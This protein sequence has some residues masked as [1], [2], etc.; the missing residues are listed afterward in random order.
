MPKP[1]DESN[2]GPIEPGME[3][4]MKAIATA[5]DELFNPG[6]NGAD[7]QI[8]FV[9]LTFPYGTKEGRSNYLSN[10]ASRDDMARMFDE[11]VKRFRMGLVESGKFKMVECPTCKHHRLRER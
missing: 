4:W 3:A 5:L 8:G 7:K 6:L 9:L 1:S 11:L 10:G 2:H